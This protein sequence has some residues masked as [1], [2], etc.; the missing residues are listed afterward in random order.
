MTRRQSKHLDFT[1][2]EISR[3]E[4]KHFSL[5]GV[6][7]FIQYFIE[8]PLWYS[9]DHVCRIS[10]DTNLQDLVKKETTPHTLYAET[11]GCWRRVFSSTWNIEAFVVADKRG[12][13]LQSLL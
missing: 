12:D 5:S 4:I 1:T 7:I 3:E 13:F 2:S 11:N 9:E 6:E 8:R 10:G